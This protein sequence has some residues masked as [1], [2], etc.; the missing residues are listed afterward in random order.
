MRLSH[1][2]KRPKTIQVDVRSITRRIADMNDKI[3]T[4]L[5]LIEP[6]EN[7]FL[8]YDCTT[9]QVLSSIQ[10]ALAH[11]GQLSVRFSALLFHFINMST[12]QVSRTY[13]P[14]CT[15]HVRGDCTL[16]IRSTVLV[17]TV[18]Y[19]GEPRTSGGDPVRAYFVTGDK[20]QDIIDDIAVHVDDRQNG[21]YELSFRLFYHLR[22]L[23]DFFCFT[24]HTQQAYITWT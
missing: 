2:N 23:H 14:L 16:Y 24:G 15:A 8:K 10:N 13:P 1:T 11:F 5:T 12:V 9:E 22:S 17:T 6:R 20:L 4:S 3:D 19:H 7:A 18:D 21:T